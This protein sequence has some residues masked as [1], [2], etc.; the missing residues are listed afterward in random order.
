MS[1][2]IPAKN[3]EQFSIFLFLPNLN[4]V[5]IKTKYSGYSPILQ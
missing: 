3:D 2:R 1:D 5:V 4:K